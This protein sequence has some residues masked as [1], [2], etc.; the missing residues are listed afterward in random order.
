MRKGA[1]LL[2]NEDGTVLF[3]AIVFLALL[4]LVGVSSISTSTTEV[5]IASNAQYNKIE[6]LNNKDFGSTDLK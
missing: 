3:V 5:R 6:F 1:H 2:G 4:T